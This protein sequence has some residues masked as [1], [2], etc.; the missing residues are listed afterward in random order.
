MDVRWFRCAGGLVLELNLDLEAARRVAEKD[1]S[2]LFGPVLRSHV[3]GHRVCRRGVVDVINR[4]GR[5]SGAGGD[6]RGEACQEK[7]GR[8]FH[9]A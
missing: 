3:N 5:G 1:L 9:H 6:R 2:I 7:K 4:I 8:D